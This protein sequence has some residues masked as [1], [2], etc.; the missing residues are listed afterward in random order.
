MGLVNSEEADRVGPYVAQGLVGGE[1]T[2]I[3]LTGSIWRADS[4]TR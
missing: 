4:L 3:I 1:I 2:P